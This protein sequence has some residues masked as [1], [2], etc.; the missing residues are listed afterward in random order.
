M[1]VRRVGHPKADARESGGEPLHSK[2]SRAKPARRPPAT[3]SHG[4][5]KT[6]ALRCMLAGLKTGAY[7]CGASLGLALTNAG[8]VKPAYRRQAALQRIG[9]G[10][11]RGVLLREGPLSHF[12][13]PNQKC[14]EAKGDFDESP[15]ADGAGMPEKPGPSEHGEDSR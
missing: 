1:Q 2:P 12:P 14:E 10:W 9:G 15:F 8:G 6:L 3:K 7:K 13:G 4:A 5:R 11:A